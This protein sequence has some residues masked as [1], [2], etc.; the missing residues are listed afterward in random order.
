[1]EKSDNDDKYIVALKHEL[2]KTKKQLLGGVETKIIYKSRDV[3]DS[4]KVVKKE[5]DEVKK[6]YIY[7]PLE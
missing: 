7:V 6:V 4:I 2:E 5:D 1:M 3:E